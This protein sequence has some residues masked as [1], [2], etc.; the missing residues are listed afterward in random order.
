L[1][2]ACLTFTQSGEQIA[3]T[4]RTA[5]R[6]LVSGGAQVDIFT[7]SDYKEH[8]HD[9]FREYT[10]IVFIS[11]TGIAVRLSAPF[12]QDK[13]RDPAV[14]VV[15]DLGRYAISLISGHLGGANDLANEIA[16]I[17]DCQPIITTASDGRGIEAVD[18]FAKRNNLFIE[19]QSDAKIITAMMVEGQPIR[20]ISEI[21]ARIGYDS[22]V[23]DNPAGCIYVT[24]QEQ[25][26]C[27]VPYCILRPKN[28]NVGLGCRRGKTKEEILRAITQVFQEHNLNVNSIKTVATIDVKKDEA[29]ILE[30]CEAL[31]CELHFYTR[32]DIKQVQHRFSASELVQ[33]TIGVS[34]VCEPCAYLAGGEIIVE[35]T[36]IDG[37]TVA[38]TR[39]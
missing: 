37:I 5:F 27:D 33:S 34:A 29:G 18:L 25:I 31:Q 2:I 16:N 20:L 7:K 39:E 10:G 13:T 8:L 12:L 14:V 9:I 28:L 4:I 3:A 1:K 23:D 6:K 38:V 21:D 35:K 11:S 17:L 30:T 24:S 15:D 32:E 19:N 26:N 36:I 22:I